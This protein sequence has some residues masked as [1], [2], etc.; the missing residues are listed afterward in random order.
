MSYLIFILITYPVEQFSEVRHRMLGLQFK[1]YEAD[2]REHFGGMLPK[3][4]FDFDKDVKSISVN[5]WA[6]GY[7][8]GGPGDSTRIGRQPFGRITIANSDSGR[9]WPVPD[10]S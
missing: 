4:L 8:L 3:E 2:I 9:Y 10:C 6:H 7:S 5:R 1:D